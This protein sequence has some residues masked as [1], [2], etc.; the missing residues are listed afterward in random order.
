MWVREGNRLSFHTSNRFRRIVMRA[1]IEQ[2][3]G[4]VVALSIEESQ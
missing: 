3:L 1:L 4:S 2:T